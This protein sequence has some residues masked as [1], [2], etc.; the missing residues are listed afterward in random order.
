MS[1]IATAQLSSYRDTIDNLDAALVSILAERFKCTTAVGFLK[2]E[3]NLSAVDEAR[4][5][6]QLERLRKLA[7]DAKL[8]GDFIEM[9]MKSII[10]EVVKRHRQIASEFGKVITR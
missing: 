4:E 3:N 8:D 1:D 7:E 6:R 9:V 10:A 5:G 2:A